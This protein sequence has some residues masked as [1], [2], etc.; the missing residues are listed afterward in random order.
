[1]ETKAMYS[2]TYGLFV[3]TASENGKDSGCIINTASQVTTTPNCI[4]ICV[5]KQNNT[6]DMVM[7]TKKLTVSVLSEKAS[8]SIFER[9]GF[10]SGRD[11]DKFA[12]FDGWKRG[13]NGV[14]YVTEG[15]NAFISAWVTETVDL[16]THTL[17]ICAV[18]DC[19]K[20]SA[21]NSC[22]YSYY[23]NNIK[24]KPQPKTEGKTKW[25]CSVCGYEYEGE[26][27][28]EDFICPLCKHPAS[29][30]VKQ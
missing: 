4:T 7:R 3:L 18:T 25:V 30:F 10:H 27:I 8:F 22:T 19:E 17:F 6:H 2:L 23:L 13:Y 20:L 28:P 29:D 5:N 1:M 14:P 9:F 24:P 11:T 21:D 16:G 12:G 26:T 15:T